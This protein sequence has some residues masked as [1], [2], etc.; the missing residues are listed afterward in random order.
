ME[1]CENVRG[2]FSRDSVV[3]TDVSCAVC[4]EVVFIS[5][6]DPYGWY[7]IQGGHPGDYQANI[8]P[9]RYIHKNMFGLVDRNKNKTKLTMSGSHGL[10]KMGS[11]E[12]MTLD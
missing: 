3:A 6:G 12:A 2:C 11:S 10:N 7:L 5:T 4:M 9:Y 1:N 8:S